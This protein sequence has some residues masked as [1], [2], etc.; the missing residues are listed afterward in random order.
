MGTPTHPVDPDNQGEPCDFCEALAWGVGKTPLLVRVIFHGVVAE[1]GMPDPPNDKPFYCEQ[2]ISP[3][4]GWSTWLTFGGFN[5]TIFYDARTSEIQ[6]EMVTGGNFLYFTGT[7][8][9]CM[10]GPHPNAIIPGTAYGYGG[11]AYVLDLP[12]DYIE[13]LA[14]TYNL[15][16][17]ARGLYD[18]DPTADPDVQLVRLTGRNCPGSCLIHFRPGDV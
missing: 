3:F 5:W 10:A 13:L 14:V 16:P 11:S 7:G 15:Q 18:S 4:C 17:D 2:G 9:Q 1:A 6:L 8:P 12:L